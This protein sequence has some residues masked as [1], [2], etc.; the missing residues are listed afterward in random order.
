MKIAVIS[1]LHYSRQKNAGCPERLGEKAPE[2]LTRALE[3]LRNGSRPD[4]LL[5]G[6]DLV[7][8]P[9]DDALLSELAGILNTADCPRIVIPGNHDPA[10]EVFYRYF[11]RPAAWQD[12][13]RLRF[14]AFPDDVQTA[15][16]N[17]FRSAEALEATVR[18]GRNSPFPLVLF[19]HVPLFR[20]GT[21]ACPYN[22]DNADEILDIAGLNKV[23]LSVSG[24]YHT[25]Y[26]PSF[27]SPVVS[28]AAP[29][30]CDRR[31]SFLVL[32]MGGEGMLK[33]C[34]FEYLEE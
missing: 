1:D 12:I 9:N 29:A 22:Y 32:E 21:V 23:V 30:L 13:G 33:S 11:P 24:H 4:V 8:D 19:Q 3:R 2:L 6:G 34:A 16:Y 26:M 5:I 31:F 7:N 14:L 10:P 28:V 27:L 18:A 20:K 25:G 17:A 15:G